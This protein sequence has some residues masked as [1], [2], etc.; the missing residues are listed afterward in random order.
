MRRRATWLSISG[1][2][3]LASFGLYLFVRGMAGPT[4]PRTDGVASGVFSWQPP[5]ALVTDLSD[6]LAGALTEVA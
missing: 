3:L 5:V 2:L 6:L 4:S 1:L